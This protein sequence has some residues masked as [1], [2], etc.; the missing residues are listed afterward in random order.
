[1]D[2]FEVREALVDVEDMVDDGIECMR[3]KVGR[4]RASLQI[5]ETRSYVNLISDVCANAA[6]KR[7]IHKLNSILLSSP[8]SPDFGTPLT[9]HHGQRMANKVRACVPRDGSRTREQP[10]H[11]PSPWL[12]VAI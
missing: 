11:G 3:R 10:T 2:D 1:M 12:S 7:C 5:A 4:R 8:S 6:T 9:S